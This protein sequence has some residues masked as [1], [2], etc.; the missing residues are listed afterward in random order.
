M[1]ATSANQ[2]TAMAI[3]EHEPDKLYSANKGMLKMSKSQ[4]HDFASTKGLGAPTGATTPKPPAI[5]KG[6]GA[7]IGN[8]SLKPKS[9]SRVGNQ[10]AGGLIPSNR[11][12]T[13]GV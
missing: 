4:L 6:L 13:S 2:R 3:A 1:P 5:P 7:G 10:K 11:K 12:L 9:L 8:G